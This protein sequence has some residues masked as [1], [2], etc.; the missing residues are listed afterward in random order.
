MY[1]RQWT[2]TASPERLLIVQ[3][4][5]T[6]PALRARRGDFLDWFQRGL[7]LRVVDIDVVRVDIGESLP[8]VAAH[9]ANGDCP[10]P[11]CV[12]R[13][14]APAPRAARLLRRFRRMAS[15]T[16]SRIA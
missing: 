1:C 8:P 3:T 10:A 9:A 14:C 5:S 4:G 6:L 7:G 13:A 15:E 2:E 11:C 12:R 16:S